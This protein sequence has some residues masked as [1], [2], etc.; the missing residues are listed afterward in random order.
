MRRVLAIEIGA[1]ITA[2]SIIVAILLIINVGQTE[3]WW[4]NV[5]QHGVYSLTIFLGTIWVT[6]CIMTLLRSI[7]L[8]LK[9]AR[10]QT[11][12]AYDLSYNLFLLALIGTAIFIFITLISPVR[13]AF[14]RSPFLPLQISA[15][16]WM[17]PMLFALLVFY[18]VI[19]VY[20]PALIANLLYRLKKIFHL[21]P[22]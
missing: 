1:L 5:E 14:F 19:L 11:P 12:V 4:R 6:A 20:K 3:A 8:A 15:P 21:P 13:A 9:Y 16:N 17:F 2:E 22:D 7:S 10:T 18:T